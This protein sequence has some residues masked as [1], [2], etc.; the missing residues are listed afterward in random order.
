MSATASPPGDAAPRESL[1]VQLGR[2]RVVAVV[3]VDDVA[4]VAPLAASLTAGGILV[5]ELALRTP[6]ALAALREFRAAAPRVLLGAGTVLL[7]EQAD[8]AR[9]PGRISRSRPDSTR[10][11]RDTAKRSD[12]RSFPAWRRRATSRRRCARDSGC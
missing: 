7:P 8:A 10:R 6:A 1:V 12:C 3:T 11:P 5:V 2:A 9:R 4:S